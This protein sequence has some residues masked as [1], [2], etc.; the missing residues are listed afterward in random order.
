M[1]DHEFR[2]NLRGFIAHCERQDRQPPDWQVDNWGADGW[3][4]M[5]NAPLFRLVDKCD[6]VVAYGFDTKGEAEQYIQ[7]AI[8]SW[9]RRRAH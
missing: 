6:A 9:V 5:D 4:A 7:E 8:K 3:A 2:A 1:T